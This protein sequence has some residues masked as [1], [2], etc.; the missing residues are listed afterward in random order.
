[1]YADCILVV[2]WL[3]YASSCHLLQPLNLNVVHKLHTTLISHESSI[4]I[5]NLSKR[6]SRLKPPPSL[7]LPARLLLQGQVLEACPVLCLH[8]LDLSP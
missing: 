5:A 8:L 3:Q 2:L 1:M 6:T 7:R 4:C